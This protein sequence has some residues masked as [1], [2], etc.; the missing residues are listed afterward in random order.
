[1]SEPCGCC[2]PTSGTTPEDIFNRPA[3]SAIAYRVGTYASFRQSMLTA[4]SQTDLGEDGKSHRPLSGWSTRRDDDYGITLLDMWAY[5]A[6]ILTFYQERIANEAYLRTALQR[7]SIIRLSDLIGYRLAPGVAAKTYL[8]YLLE[9]NTTLEIPERMRVQ[10]VPA[11][12]ETA[13]KF[14]TVESLEAQTLFNHFRVYPEPQACSPLGAGRESATVTSDISAIK[15]GNV[16]V[17]YAPGYTAGTYRA[18]AAA[19]NWTAIRAMLIEEKEITANEAVDWRQ[20]LSWKPSVRTAYGSGAMTRK[21]RKKIRL[22]GHNA[23]SQYFSASVSSAGD[24]SWAKHSVN[25]YLSQSKTLQLDAAYDDLKVN[26][27]I[28]LTAGLYADGAVVKEYLVTSVEKTKATFPDSSSTTPAL[29]AAVTQ[30]LLDDYLPAGVDVRTAVVYELEGDALEFWEKEYGAALSGNAVYVPLCEL[31]DSTGTAYSAAEAAKLLEAGRRIILEDGLVTP[32]ATTVSDTQVEGDHLKITL[33]SALS[34]DLDA[35]T[36]M[37]RAN[38]LLSTHGETISKEVMGDG[39]ASKGFQSFELKKSPLTY[40]PEAGAENGAASTL[41]VR[42]ENILWDEV[43]T[44]YGQNDRAR[45][46][47][48]RIDDEKTATVRFGDG[49]TG[50]RLPSGKKNLVVRYRQGIGVDGNVK[51]GS[52]TTALDKP[53][54]VKSVTNPIAAG[55]GSDPETLSQART[56]APT[57]VRTL[58]RIVS[59]SDFEDAARAYAGIAKAK[60]DWQWD[61][62]E[63]AVLLTVA[64]DDGATIESGGTTHA[65]L[66]A[67][68]DSRRD[69]HRK[70]TVDSF[71]PIPVKITAAIQVASEMDDETVQAEALAALEA[72]L[73]FDNLDLGQSIHLSDVMRVL[74]SVEGVEAADVDALQYKNTADRDAHGALPQAVLAHLPIFPNEL[75][76]VSDPQNDLIVNLGLSQA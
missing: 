47:T 1:M 49:Q 3:L 28:L 74:Q 18:I 55:G 8:A 52:L 41:E 62:M 25:P 6:D 54:G 27:R 2:K 22:F 11:A 66:V 32:Q 50:T 24:V 36:A 13:Q 31:V 67:D 12:G 19:V 63:Q 58:G 68:L 43:S 59:L 21:W 10:S 33:D 45:V 15:K 64:G 9:K 38:V 71:K 57:T 23:P 60:A 76:A 17:M 70:L 48:I 53:V 56:N 61:G 73:A 44:L 51:A 46:Y 26:T 16:I 34:S 72:Y 39:D 30:I 5:L 7:D 65:D 29:E 4:I 42:V 75:A 14:E 37:A 20:V 69:P 35:E 40:V